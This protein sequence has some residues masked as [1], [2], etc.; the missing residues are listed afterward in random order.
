VTTPF[1][2]ATSGNVGNTRFLGGNVSISG[3]VNVL[4][5]VVAP[6]FAGDGSLLSNITTSGGTSINNGTSNVV[7]TTNGNIYMGVAGVSNV[8]GL[9]GNALTI[10]GNVVISTIGNSVATYGNYAP[11]VVDT[12]TN[13]LRKKPVEVVRFSGDTTY[14]ATAGEGLMLMYKD[15]VMAS[16]IGYSTSL[17]TCGYIQYNPVLAPVFFPSA[18]TPIP[19][20]AN[21]YNN[22]FNAAALTTDGRVF[23]WG[24][25]Y[26]TSAVGNFIPIQVNLPQSVTQLSGGLLRVNNSGGLI[27]SA[28]FGAVL[29]NGQLYMWG[30]NEYGTLGRGTTESTSNNTPAIPN[31]L[32]SANITK[33]T[34][35]AGWPGTVAALAS[36]G[37]LFT[38]GYNSIGECGLGNTSTSVNIPCI[39]PGVSNVTDVQ[40][41][42]AY[43][44]INLNTRDNTSIRVLCGNG[45]SFACGYNGQGELAIGNTVTMTTFVRENSNRSNIAAIGGLTNG[46]DDVHFIIQND[47]QMLFSG[48]KPMVGISN[49]TT[50]TSTFY[51]G[52]GFSSLG[53]QRNMLSN[54]GTPVVTPRIHSAFGPDTNQYY[55][56]GILDNTGNLYAFGYNTLGNWG[57]TT[58]TDIA[59]FKQL[60]QYFPSQKRATDFMMTG[61]LN[62]YGGAVIALSDGTLI[63]C[64]KNSSGSVPY[65]YVISGVVVPVYKY[66]IGFSPVDVN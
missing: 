33:V 2:V 21:Y 3:Q 55:Q 24:R 44:G 12:A 27:V 1:I 61:Y 51:N 14:C 47:G 50:I 57:D 31:G 38:W 45:T 30:W 20:F 39:V 15:Q 17:Q 58:T 4:G 11:V 18:T 53:F 60:N 40:F 36:N 28:I 25:N 64:G 63:G 42:N 34:I 66:L 35:S 8:F 54:V 22:E 49:A 62:S 19:G 32:A 7:V 43:S 23:A 37:R 9:T 65:E 26:G 13:T 59:S 48:Y 16:G 46:R 29:G 41:M 56:A 6:F 5:T 10:G 52:D